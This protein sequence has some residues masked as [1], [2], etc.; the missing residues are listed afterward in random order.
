MAVLLRSRGGE[1]GYDEVT[2][3]GELCELAKN[4]SLELLKVLLDCG[5]PI[6]AADYDKRTC[7]HL[8]CSV[9]NLPICELLIERGADVN[10]QDRFSLRASNLAH[11]TELLTSA[12]LPPYADGAVRLCATLFARGARKWRCS[13]TRAAAPSATA[14]WRRAVSSASWPSKAA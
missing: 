8:A 14:R 5:C 11:P 3:S 4:G 10:A 7:L 1:L 13:C 12:A 2:A 9:G 6:N